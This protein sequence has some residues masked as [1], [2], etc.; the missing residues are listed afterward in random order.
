MKVLVTGGAG[1]I[2]SNLVKELAKEHEVIVLD[3]LF[4]GTKD[5]LVD[6]DV[7]FIQGSVTDQEV[8]NKACKNCDYIFHNAAMSSSPMFKSGPESGFRINVDG[9]INVM[10]AALQCD[11]KKVIYASTSSMYNGNRL[12]YSEKQ[13]T[14]AK[15]FYEASFRCREIVAQTYYFEH[16]LPSIGLR[17]FSV[18]GPN[19]VHKRIY[20]NNVSQFLWSM[21]RGTRP[22]IY[23]DGSQTRDFT[24]VKDVVKANMLAAESE[25]EFGIFNVGTSVAT[26][27]NSLVSILNEKLG[28]D[29]EPMYVQNPIKNYVKHTVADLKLVSKLLGYKP[30]W[31]LEKGIEY[32][33][34]YAKIKT[35]V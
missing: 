8:V 28:T 35:A 23:G 27:F 1:F 19:E 31:N 20:A 32:L 17:Y 9:F 12:P 16:H 15:T 5:N 33:I 34:D 3:N 4:L 25:I 11:V 29:I 30:S 6:L 18:Y 13:P 10:Q 22:V 14:S 21:I 7:K 26:S 2:G 24:F